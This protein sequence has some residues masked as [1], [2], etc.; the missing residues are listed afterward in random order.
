MNALDEIHAFAWTGR[1]ES[2]LRLAH[3]VSSISEEAS[4]PTYSVIRLCESLLAQGEEVS[5]LTLDWAT[6]T[7][8][9]HFARSFRMGR[10]PRKLGRSS[11]MHQW[12]AQQVG[13]SNFDVIHAHGLWMMPNVYPGWVA[14]RHGLPLVVSPRGCFTPYAMASGSKIKRLFWPLVQRPALAA[15]T[16]FHATAES[17]YHDIRRM[18]FRQ[19]VA[20]IPNGI[21]LQDLVPKLSGDRRMLLFLGRLHHNKGLDML[22]PAWARVQA[23]FPDWELLIVGS[24]DGYHGSSGFSDEMKALSIRLGLE[25]IRF[26][27][28]RYGSEKLRMFR[29]AS[30]YVLP[31]YSENFGVTVA[32][33]LSQATPAIVTKGAPWKGLELNRAG[34]WI[35]IGVEPLVAAL[36][37]ALDQP[38]DV[39]SAMGENGRAWMQSQFLWLNIARQMSGVYRWS[40][41]TSE[42]RPAFVHL[43]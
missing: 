28:P 40:R 30:L 6:N 9:P 3:I 13:G 1:W 5:L 31:T 26:E 12:L 10:G 4:G 14:G 22:L 37:T 21:D 7:V 23:R 39:L 17:E 20:I 2:G 33:A 8:Y 11:A 42:G 36:E 16:C 18:G 38:E 35:D 29:N 43:D 32:E 34:W 27:G 25:R 41:D 24:D 15:V 19:P